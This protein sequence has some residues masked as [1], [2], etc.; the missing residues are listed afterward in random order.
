MIGYQNGLTCVIVVALR[1]WPDNFSEPFVVYINLFYSHIETTCLN[2]NNY[3]LTTNAAKINSRHSEAS[4]KKVTPRNVNDTRN[5]W[6]V[7]GPVIALSDIHKLD[8][9]NKVSAAIENKNNRDDRLSHLV[10]IILSYTWSG[11]INIQ[12]HLKARMLYA[13]ENGCCKHLGM[14]ALGTPDCVASHERGVM[15]YIRA[16]ININSCIA[17]QIFINE[18]NVWD[19]KFKSSLGFLFAFVEISMTP[20]HKFYSPR[21]RRWSLFIC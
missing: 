18:L 5:R 10:A 7:E 20:R 17:E 11:I 15:I 9:N 12:C 13:Y 4:H 3:N 16:N 1:L 2:V 8:E 14:V 6:R 19:H 21:F